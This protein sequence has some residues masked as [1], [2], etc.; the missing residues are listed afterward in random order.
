[1]HLQ[2]IVTKLHLSFVDVPIRSMEQQQQQQ[3]QHSQATKQDANPR[4][5]LIPS[6]SLAWHYFTEI[7]CQKYST[8]RYEPN[9]RITVE[10]PMES[11]D[12]TMRTTNHQ[13][14][15][16]SSRY[17]QKGHEALARRIWSSNAPT[18]AGLYHHVA[19][20]DSSDWQY[21]PIACCHEAKIINRIRSIETPVVVSF[22]PTQP[23]RIQA[24]VDSV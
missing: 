22:Q 6:E 2:H 8:R 3:Q 18:R 24:S 15:H 21:Y 20:K 7:R 13:W 4:E 23:K 17:N 11:I 1:M 16:D 19:T 5:I 14:R 10:N 12:G 9:R